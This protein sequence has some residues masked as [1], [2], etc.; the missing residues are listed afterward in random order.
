EARRGRPAHRG[1]RGREGLRLLYGAV[2]L[3]GPRAGPQDRCRGAAA[4]LED[5]RG[6]RAPARRRRRSGGLLGRRPGQRRRR[7]WRERGRTTRR[8]GLEAGSPGG[9]SAQRGPRGRGGLLAA[10]PP[11]ALLPPLLGAHPL[12]TV[13]LFLDLRLRCASR[14][15]ALVAR[16]MGSLAL[17]ACFFVYFEGGTSRTSDPGCEA[18]ST[19]ERVFRHVAVGVL[20]SFVAAV[21]TRLAA[22]FLVR[23]R[24]LYR[25]RWDEGN[26]R[27]MLRSWRCA[28]LAHSCFLASYSLCAIFF[29]AVFLSHAS[30]ATGTEWSVSCSFALLKDTFLLPLAACLL[31]C[32]GSKVHS[33]ADPQAALR[34]RQPF[35]GAQQKLRDAG[36]PAGGAAEE[37]AKALQPRS[38]ECPPGA[39]RAGRAPG[40]GGAARWP[41][42]APP[43]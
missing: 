6:A 4:D 40:G 36:T 42:T 13:T 12:W 29:T 2:Q 19:R 30:E 28:D 11:G 24:F 39:S 18:E 16:V 3:P 34:A 17:N 21:P 33:L 41:G 38:A 27:R 14:A 1:H 20:T 26:R 15:L 35:E 10:G 25:E 9:E 5:G 23:R 43:A 8:G 31:L 37:K 7:T 22:F 32:T